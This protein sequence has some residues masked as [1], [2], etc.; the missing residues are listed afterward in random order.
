MIR[1]IKEGTMPRTYPAHCSHCGCDFTFERVDII[2]WAWNSL[3]P[4]STAESSYVPCPC[5]GMPFY[6]FTESIYKRKD[7]IP[8]YSNDLKLD[9]T[10]FTTLKKER[11]QS[12][13]EI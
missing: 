7:F 5:C 12:D 11:C 3:T 9:D 13:E 8:Y 10:Y 2:D 6:T 4:S 1:V